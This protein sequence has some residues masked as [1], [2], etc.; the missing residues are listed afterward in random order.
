VRY[1]MRHFDVSSLKGDIEMK[2]YISLICLALAAGTTAC[3][4]ACEVNEDTSRWVTGTVKHIELEG[5]FY[6]IVGDQGNKFDPV[7]LPDRF[8]EDGL[9]VKACMKQLE[10]RVSFRMW[11]TLVEIIEIKRL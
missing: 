6:G 9:R 7:N 3:R 1:S 8:K 5:G 11:G 4:T 10:D 2:V